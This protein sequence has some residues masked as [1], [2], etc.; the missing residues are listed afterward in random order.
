MVLS[1]RRPGGAPPVTLRGTF[2]VGITCEQPL[3][4]I[5]VSGGGGT[6]T[7]VTDPGTPGS[8]PQSRS[9]NP[10]QSTIS[11]RIPT[12]SEAFSSAAHVATAAVAAVVVILFITFPSQ[13]FDSTF[14]EYHDEIKGFVARRLRRGPAAA[15]PHAGRDAIAFAGV[16]VAGAL[17]GGFLDPGFGINGASLLT[18]LATTAATLVAVFI[19]VAVAIA[20]RR[21]RGLP[22]QRRLTALPSGL[23]IAALCVL[24][25]RISD[26]QPGYLYGCVCGVAFSQTLEV[27]DRGKAALLGVAVTLT[28][29]VGAW[30][31]WTPLQNDIASAGDGVVLAADVLGAVFSGGLVGTVIGM[32]PVGFL[33]GGKV[34]AWNRIAWAGA[35]FVACFLLVAVMLN[36]SSAAAHTGSAPIVTAV[37]LFGGFGAASVVFHLWARSLRRSAIEDAA[38]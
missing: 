18:F 29:A 3:A 13:L 32:I 14:K 17:L 33:N 16:V 8:I 7:P 1:T 24:I 26:F 15:G 25:S 5:A 21:I 36:P 31:A 30:L 38:A 6:G 19:P 11:S 22:Q 12:P 35:F 27:R 9:Y 10:Q 20:Y 28:V 4:S 2:C 37:V 34:F 23:L